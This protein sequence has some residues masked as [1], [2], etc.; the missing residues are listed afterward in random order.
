[1]SRSAVEKMMKIVDFLLN[2]FSLR[3]PSY[4]FQFIFKAEIKCQRLKKKNFKK[5][6]P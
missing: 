4:Y 6:S 3:I 2:K 5:F 1:M